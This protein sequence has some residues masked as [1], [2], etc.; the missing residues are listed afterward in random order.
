MT[1]TS[2][3]PGA[4]RPAATSGEE[5]AGL[6]AAQHA[7]LREAWCRVPLLHGRARED[8]FL[9][10]RRMLAVHVALERVVLA[11]RL[12]EVDGQELAIDHEV[13][14]AELEGLESLDFDV[15]CARIAVAFLRHSADVDQQLVLTGPL[16]ERDRRAVD[17]AV[18]LW[19][20]D[21]D[22]YPGNTWAEMVSTAVGQLTAID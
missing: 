18:A 9:H 13:V 6:L 5:L 20:G 15:A 19:E 3:E 7:Y 1:G 4:G 22:A 14:A 16:P 17:T 12:G 11:P 2:H 10:A 8:V 21:G